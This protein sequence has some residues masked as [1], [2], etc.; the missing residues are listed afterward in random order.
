M[1]CYDIIPNPAIRNSMR[2]MRRLHFALTGARTPPVAD[3]VLAISHY[4]L[5]DLKTWV[6]Q[7]GLVMPPAD[8]VRLGSMTGAGSAARRCFARRAQPGKYLSW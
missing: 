1:T 4:T 2:P 5:A 7:R 6:I 3:R 8:V